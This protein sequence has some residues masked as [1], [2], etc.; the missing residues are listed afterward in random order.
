MTIVTDSNVKLQNVLNRLE[1]GEKL[2]SGELRRGDNF[3]I[4][5]MLADE[6]GL[7]EW[8]SIYEHQSPT[9][10]ASLDS[11]FAYYHIAD[12]GYFTLPS[13]PETLRNKI[14]HNLPHLDY[15]RYWDHK[16]PWFIN[17]SSINDQMIMRCIDIKVVNSIMSDLLRFVSPLVD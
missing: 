10:T 1:N 8:F 4:M 15:E 11:I 13:L 16:S 2:I 9:Y 14:M 6:S 7:G 12:T 5:G 3:C 17:L